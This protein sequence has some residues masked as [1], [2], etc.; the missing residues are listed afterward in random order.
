MASNL[1]AAYWE[2]NPDAL[3]V[4]SPQGLVLEWNPAAEAIFGYAQ[5]DAQGRPSWS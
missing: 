4:L 1:S 5:A 3:L 2:Q